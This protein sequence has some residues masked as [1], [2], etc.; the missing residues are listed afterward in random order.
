MVKEA[1]LEY[2][3]HIYSLNSLKGL[4]HVHSKSIIKDWFSTLVV[5]S[6]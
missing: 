6:V 3:L 4:D 1:V 5:Y 2:Y